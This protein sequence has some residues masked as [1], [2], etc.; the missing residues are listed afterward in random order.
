MTHRINLSVHR[1]AWLTTLG[2]LIPILVLAG[3]LAA[4][5]EAQP[6]AA[7]KAAQPVAAAKAAPAPKVSAAE[8]VPATATSLPTARATCGARPKDSRASSA[9][10]KDLP[11]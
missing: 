1:L 4:P 7:S 6:I 2:W 5:A 11:G 9:S 10:P 3:L 8:V